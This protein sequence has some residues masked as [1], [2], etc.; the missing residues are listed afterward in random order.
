MDSGL[1]VNYSP[2][3][4]TVRNTLTVV[5]DAEPTS[6]VVVRVTTNKSGD[7]T[8][9]TDGNTAGYQD[10]LTFTPDNWNKPE[11]VILWDSRDIDA[12]I[13]TSFTVV[14]NQSA[15]EYE[16]VSITRVLS[17]KLGQIDYSAPALSTLDTISIR[18]GESE[19][20]K[21]VLRRKPTSN[22]VV[23]ITFSEQTEFLLSST[24]LTFTPN[25]WNTPQTVT[26]S[27]GGN[28]GISFSWVSLTHSVVADESADEYDNAPDQIW[29]LS[30]WDTSAS[31]V[32]TAAN[33]MIIEEGGS[34]TYTVALRTRPSSNV[35]VIA[36][37]WHS[38]VTVDTDATRPGKQ[39]RLTFTS[40]NWSTAQTVTAWAAQDDDSKDERAYIR[41]SV[42]SVE[43]AVEF[44]Y[45]LPG[46]VYW[47]LTDDEP[48]VSVSVTELALAE[49]GS[50]AYTVV[51]EER[52]THDVVIGVTASGSPDV[53]VDRA[54][55]TFTSSN[56]STAQTVT[57]RAA[58]DADAVNDAA[59]ISHAVDASR[60]ANEYVNLDIDGVRVTVD[61]DET[62]GISVSETALPVAEGG[63]ATYT[64]VLDASPPG[65]WGFVRIAL[66]SDNPDV[67][68]DRATLRFNRSNWDTAQTVT[69][70]AA[71]DA[72]AVN[73][74]AS[75]THKAL[76][77]AGTDYYHY[78]A[79]DV[80]LPVT[81]DDDDDAG[82]SVSV[83]ELAVAEGG[84]AAYTVVLDA[85][86][87]GN[88]VIGV[89]ASG[90][91]DVTV[92]RA[93]LRFNRS[94][95]DTAQTVTV[96]AAQDADAANDAASITHAVD[97]SRS[98]NEYGNL[99]I[100]GVRVTVDDDETVGISVSETALPVAE[101]GSA[102]YT[103][104]LDASPPG[105]WGFV[106][107]ALSS[108]N[109]DVTVDRATLR[110]NRSNWDT[111]QTVTVRAAQ[112]ADAVNDAASI[113]HKALPVAGTDYYHYRALDVAL[114]VTVADDE[115][116]GVS[117]SVTE[118]AVAEGGSA[119]YT[120]VLDALPASDV[121][122]GVTASGSPDVTVDRATLTFS[123]SN[124]DT[125]QTVTVRAAQDADAVNDA[126]SI[127]HAVDASRSADE[128]D[129]VAVGGVSVSVADDDAGV[130]MSVADDD[131]GVSVSVTELAL[132]EGGQ[133]AY[134]V[135]L[136]A[137]PASD[138]VITVSSDNSD[139]TADRATLTFSPS[140]WDTAQTVT[141]SA[142]QDADAV[143]DAAS[144]THAVDASRSADEYDAVSV[145][146]VAV[147]VA[148]DDTAGVSVSETTLTVAEGNSSTYTVV[149]DAQPASDVVITVS[150]DNSDVT[151]DTDAATSGNQTTLTF[152]S[153]NWD[154]A[155]TVT[156]RAAQDADAVNDAASITHAVD[157]SRSADEYDAVSVAG[158]AV[159]VADD[160]AGVSVSETTL[161][162][163]E[164]NSSTYTVVLDAQPASDVVIGV[165]A[166]GSPDVTVDRATLT[167]SPSNWDT[168]QTV[169]VRA[170]QDADA[171][172]DAAS[173][174]HAV[175][176]A[177]SADEYDAVSVAGVAVTVADDDT[178]G[179]SVSETTLT[180]AEGNS[181]TYTVVL[182]AQ[183]AS[184]V[185]IT[186]NQ[187]GA[188]AP[189]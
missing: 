15:D 165:T 13:N 139:V 25:N 181:S 56:W 110:F 174:T 57:V 169:T 24:S 108:D 59:S 51:L 164:G 109:P 33:P 27:V 136:D 187:F 88:V 175:V 103:V 117:V 91:P 7:V 19:S 161:T 186:V 95:W 132:A 35:V 30:T 78:R 114:P 49:G 153:S 23:S 154:T 158:V 118:L 170:A 100:D 145:A 75:I 14:D 146:G 58:Q 80:A 79:L 97:A 37:V 188:A 112:D 178:A 113:T 66:S 120:V 54:T 167:F 183:P 155:Q 32:V 40:S 28:K 8:V 98:A 142:A 71:Q 130:S 147:T 106:R 29:Y 163:A 4:N 156:V 185:V 39:N 48:G 38:D 93:T 60:S 65:D 52:P 160:D 172:N 82:V 107:I 45:A 122:I 31:L 77:V 3:I 72:D 166:S 148:D 55:L 76:P 157:A 26:L 62:V 17:L 12:F 129:G 92:D 5:L 34:A 115:T 83:T 9:D 150:S 10:T 81:V 177:S 85:L 61:D 53:T 149:L 84:S 173:I 101:G 121:V 152:T 73:D 144:I 151:A 68:V 96:R 87:S 43:S 135:V 90:S 6:R 134:T 50:A 74:A 64:V 137:L 123:P 104:V 47:I 140:N 1:T 36:H 131:A 41:M 22:V 67:T 89:T 44:H 127:T 20:Y 133:A 105:D 159:T 176:A 171:V 42:V 119:A 141:V 128:Y 189:T 162:V 16:G 63:S 182:D 69:V 184:D 180:V 168:A 21:V 138:V 99:D 179:V 143:N 124:W 11:E 18:N 70:R 116:A 111:A 94:N 86:P 126:A 125:A 46:Y 102:T 2:T